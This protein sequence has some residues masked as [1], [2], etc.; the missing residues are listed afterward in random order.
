MQSLINLMFLGHGVP[1]KICTV[2]ALNEAAFH[3]QRDPHSYIHGRPCVDVFSLCM[4]QK[5]TP[6]EAALVDSRDGL[7]LLLFLCWEAFFVQKR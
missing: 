6:R 1:S 3:H 2:C 5:M 4:Q 7:A